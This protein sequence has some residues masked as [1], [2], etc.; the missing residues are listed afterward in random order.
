[1]DNVFGGILKVYD[2]FRDDEQAITI[3]YDLKNPILVNIK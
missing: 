2:D 3:N 1:M